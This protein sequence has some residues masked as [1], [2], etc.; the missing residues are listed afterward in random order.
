M[1]AL[2]LEVH[3]E[4]SGGLGDPGRGRVRGDDEDADPAAGVLDH[5]EYVQS[6]AAQGVVSKKS[7]V[8]SASA[9]ERRKAAHVV[10]VRSGAGSIPA[11][12]RICHTVDAAVVVPRARSSP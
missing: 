2:V 4:V 1:S 12:L 10:E 11:S 3:D 5:R 7:Q 9:W 6:G 8:R